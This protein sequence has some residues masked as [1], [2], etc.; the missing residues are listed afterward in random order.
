M[1]SKKPPKNST[2][3]RKSR[4]PTRRNAHHLRRPGHRERRIPCHRSTNSPDADPAGLIN[5]ERPPHA[6]V[7]ASR[8]LGFIGSN[9]SQSSWSVPRAALIVHTR[10]SAE[11]LA[12]RHNRTTSAATIYKGNNES[13]TV[14]K[15]PVL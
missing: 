5:R 15:P 9:L 1:S 7:T 12:D 14:W 10:T 6:F 11:C 13:P 2:G 8:R 4:P 3:Q